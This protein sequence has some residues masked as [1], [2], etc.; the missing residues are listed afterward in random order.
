V[1]LITQNPTVDLLKDY[2]RSRGYKFE[3][4]VLSGSSYTRFISPAGR[5]W[6]TQ[7]AYISYPFTHATARRISGRKNLAY[8]LCKLCNVTA[9]WTVIVDSSTPIEELERY[10]TKGPLVVKPRRASLSR[11]LTLNVQTLE[12]LRRAIEKALSYGDLALV[13][14]QIKGEE[15]RFVVLDGKVKAA[16]LRQ[17]PSV[18][19]DGHST[20]REL[21]DIENDQRKNLKMKY[22]SYPQL[23]D[24]IIDFSH[25]NMEE[26]PAASQTVELG[27]GTMIKTGASIFNVIDEI[28][29]D[30]VATA[31]KLAHALG[32]GFVVVDIMIHNLRQPQTKDNYAFIEFNTAPVLK[33]FYSCRDGKHYDVL[34][35]LGAMIDESLQETSE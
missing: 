23:T 34:P 22:L 15:V 12:D 28:H 29:P 8:E 16:I 30:Y 17:T 25:V 13:Q 10:L 32:A 14:Q 35:K 33:L 3:Q 9:P 2:F 31:E 26:I 19:G 1:A 24:E 5:S 11:G 6:L 20:I 7:D 18:I 21:L 27:R 4:M